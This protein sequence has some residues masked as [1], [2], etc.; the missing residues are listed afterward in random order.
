MYGNGTFHSDVD[1]ERVV[2]VIQ[3]V[4]NTTHTTVASALWMKQTNNRVIRK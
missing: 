3:I 4:I 1:R 2:E